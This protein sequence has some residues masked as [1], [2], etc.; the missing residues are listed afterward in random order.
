MRKLL[1]VGQ[2]PSSTSDPKEPF[3]GPSGITIRRLMGVAE[4]DFFRDYDRI[5]VLD[6]FTGKKGKGDA[7]SKSMVPK[8]RREFLMKFVN[9]RN[10]VFFGRETARVFGIEPEFLVPDLFLV[11]KSCFRGIVAPHPSGINLFWNEPENRRS[12]KIAL[13]AFVELYS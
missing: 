4:K 9:D 5:N 7:F 1:L 6:F 13:R 10:V 11:D 12:A 8:E 3:S 2:A